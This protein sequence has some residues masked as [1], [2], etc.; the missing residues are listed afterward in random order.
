MQVTNDKS[1]QGYREKK[2]SDSDEED[3]EDKE[4][5][6]PIVK[7]ERLSPCEQQELSYDDE[8]NTPL[9][10]IHLTFDFEAGSL[11]PLALK[12]VTSEDVRPRC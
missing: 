8:T 10:G 6:K 11:L 9:S 12:L 7:T 5:V 2:I 1:T 3:E 4:D